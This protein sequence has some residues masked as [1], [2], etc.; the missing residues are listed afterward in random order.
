SNFFGLSESAHSLC[1]NK[2]HRVLIAG[3]NQKHI[4]LYDLRQNTASLQTIQTKAV[5]GLGVAPNGNYLSSFFDSAIMLW[6]L[7]SLDRSLKQI[8]SAK[9]HLQLSW[10]PTRSSLLSSLQRESPY[11]T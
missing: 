6:D 4:K 3:M 11:I 2:N 10:C 1:W 8:Q 5:Y 9:N 7:R